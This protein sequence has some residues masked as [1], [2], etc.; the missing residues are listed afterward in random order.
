MRRNKLI[1]E[2]TEFNA[3][4]LNP[5]SA[6]MS[7]QVDNPELSVGAFDRHEDSIR[8]GIS[9]INT[10]LHSLSNSSAF[11]GLKSKLMI[12]DQNVKSLKILRIIS[13]NHVNY[14]AYI[15]F[16]I[17]DVEYYGE[18]IDILSKKPTLKSEVFKD[19]TLHQP[20][21]WVIKTKGLLIKTIKKW[22]NPDKGEYMSLKDGVICYSTDTGKMLNITNG[23]VV[24]L[25]RAYDN[26]IVIKY[27]NSYYTLLNDNYVY[28]NYW[29]EKID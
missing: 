4:R 19:Y 2:F 27:K 7:V 29:F 10:I 12:D 24:N 21:E 26:K 9:R 15:S 18:I 25:E 28:F 8:H 20:K 1:L 5:D 17:G 3:Q 14:D 13:K 23:L 6:Q 22:L 11:G 16:F